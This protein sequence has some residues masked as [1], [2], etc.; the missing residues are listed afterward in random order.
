VPLGEEVEA[1]VVTIL[2]GPVGAALRTLNASNPQATYTTPQQAADFGAVLAPG[3]A[4]TFAVR[5][6]SMA[7]GLGAEAKRTV[8]VG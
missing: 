3:T 6:V 7:V 4:L 8:G 5:Q 2:A 1:Y